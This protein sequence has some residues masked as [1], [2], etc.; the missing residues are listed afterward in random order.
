MLLSTSQVFL[1]HDQKH[2]VFA[3]TRPSLN[4]SSYVAKLNPLLWNID[5][6]S[7]PN[8]HN[9]V[10]NSY[11]LQLPLNLARIRQSIVF[12]A[13]S[14][15]QTPT[16]FMFSVST[17]LE[18]VRRNTLNPQVLAAHTTRTVFIREANLTSWLSI[19]L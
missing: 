17:K 19:T 3:R 15:L 12:S 6:L 16:Q 7:R 1:Q 18:V 13:I 9:H 14:Q 2:D 4:C 8:L 5:V 11:C 10:L